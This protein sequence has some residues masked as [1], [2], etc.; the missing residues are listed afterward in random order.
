MP[1]DSIGNQADDRDVEG[2]LMTRRLDHTHDSTAR[3]WVASASDPDTD[4]PIQNLPFGV[5]RRAGSSETFRGGIAIGEHILD[6]AML[7]ETGLLNG[8]AAIAIAACAGDTLNRLLKLCP[9]VWRALR[10]GI[11]GLL[12]EANASAGPRIETCLVAQRRCEHALPFQIGDYSDFYTSLHH[13]TNIGRMFGI[14]TAGSNFEW[15]PIAYHGRAS[16]I[17]ISG[18]TFRRPRGQIKETPNAPPVLAPCRKLD[19]ELEVAIY[20]GQGNAQGQ[21]LSLAAA[22][23]AIFGLSLLNDWSARDIQAWELRPLGPFLAKSFATTV[24]PWSSPWTRWP[25]TGAHFKRT[26]GPAP[27]AYLDDPS[28]RET[29]DVDLQLDVSIETKQ[30]REQGLPPTRLSRTNFHHQYWTIA[31]MVAHHTINGCNLRPGDLLGSGTVSGPEVGEAGAMMELASNGS[32]PVRLATGET[33]SFVED[34]DTI[35]LR[36]RCERP[37]SVSIGFGECRGT[38]LPST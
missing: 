13:A 35:I 17:G 37:G 30:H 12:H 26:V 24:S 16:S 7:A 36:G 2:R 5:F 38:V 4:F 33:R 28:L 6:L 9:E 29:G 14:E 8:S 21:P 18:Q 34:G 11:F 20:I 25:R 1:D 3:S 23:D 31:Q 27:L 32:A 22:E 19:Y 15:I 10:H